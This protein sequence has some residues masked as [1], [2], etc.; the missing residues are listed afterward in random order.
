[1]A[2][3]KFISSVLGWEEQGYCLSKAI[4]SKPTRVCTYSFFHL[5]FTARRD[6]SRS[7]LGL[8]VTRSAGASQPGGAAMR[9]LPR[10]PPE[11]RAGGTTGCFQLLLL[12]PRTQHG[13][14]V[15]RSAGR[16][17]AAPGRC[18]GRDVRFPPALIPL[19][20]LITRSRAGLLT[21]T[22]WNYF[23]MSDCSSLFF[24]PV[25][26]PQTFTH[27]DAPRCGTGEPEPICEREDQRL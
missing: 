17:S 1:M 19:L 4:C 9:S 18:A 12:L 21:L 15:Q 11:M 2:L 24:F 27:T 3:W 13:S 7:T 22:E 16:G 14:S 10:F 8:W 20:T 26:Y 6:L 5:C 23:P 25:K